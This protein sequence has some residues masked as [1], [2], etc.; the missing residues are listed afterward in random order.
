MCSVEL[1]MEKF[2]KCYAEKAKIYGFYNNWNDDE[3]HGNT[4]T[5]ANE[6]K[7]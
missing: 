3:F 6:K 1:F 5:Y 7:G 4:N 2:L